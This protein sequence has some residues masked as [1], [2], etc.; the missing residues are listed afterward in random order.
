MYDLFVHVLYA[1]MHDLHVLYVTV[2]A[3]MCIIRMICVQSVNM[4]NHYVCICVYIY[5]YASC[6]GLRI[7]CMYV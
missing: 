3:H 2:C 6:L 5:I 4:V 7:L 1:F